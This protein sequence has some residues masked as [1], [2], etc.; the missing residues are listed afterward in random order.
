MS[1][2]GVPWARSRRA[3]TQQNQQLDAADTSPDGYRGHRRRVALAVGKQDARGSKVE[4]AAGPGVSPHDRPAWLGTAALDRSD[5][6]ATVEGCPARRGDAP[7]N[8][9]P[10]S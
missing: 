3:K 1:V 10:P 6:H 9:P 8:L 7:A 5:P 4:D 2:G